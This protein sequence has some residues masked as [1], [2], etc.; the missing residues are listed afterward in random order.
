MIIIVIEIFM[1]LNILHIFQLCSENVA[2]G[3]GRDT[4]KMVI[5]K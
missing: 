5:L 1:E 2:L 3:S 4:H